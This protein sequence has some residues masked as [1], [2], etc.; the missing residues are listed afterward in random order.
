ML[1]KSRKNLLF[2]TVLIN[3]NFEQIF[4]FSRKEKEKNIGDMV[5]FL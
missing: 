5:S 3:E 1:G 4:I 2:S